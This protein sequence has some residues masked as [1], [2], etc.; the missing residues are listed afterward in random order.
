[1]VTPT[2]TLIP[3]VVPSPSPEATADGP[4]K[5]KIWLPEPF[6]PPNN[7]EASILLA[8]QI[9]SFQAT[10][11]DLIVEARLKKASDVGGIMNTLRTASVVAPGALPDLTLLRREDLRV[12]VQMGL[13]QPLDGK[14]SAAVMGDFYPAAQLL[15]EVNGRLYG[16]PYGLEV[17]HL[18]YRSATDNWKTFD[19][20]LA[21]G[22]PL[23]FA[24]GG[25][26]N[27]SD[28]FLVQYLSAGGKLVD[29]KLGKPDAD[30]LHTT[31]KFYEEAVAKGVIDPSI[32]TYNTPADYLAK[33][34]DNKINA[35]VLTS[36]SYL[37]LVTKGQNLQAGVIPLASATPTTIVNAWMWVV[38]T[39]D[40]DHQALALDFLEWMFDAGRQ[41]RYSRMVNLLPAQRAAMR[42][43][44]NTHYTS[45]VEGLLANAVLPPTESAGGA[46]ARA[47][48]NALINVISGQ[49]TADQATEDVMNQLSG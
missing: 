24:A 22:K 21:E 40:A 6:A 45:F 11:A 23:V 9:D 29:G 20:A 14:I 28:V 15:G 41:A 27:I 5:L 46:A 48:Q 17:E 7:K 36:T 10:Q 49:R 44:D 39:S 12:A 25:A 19:A 34:G 43:W 18:A 26:G 32:L 13:A 31:L 47:M 8:D 37:D 2:V 16:L 42:Q 38:T 35:A 30:A 33:F 3:T 1:M 4:R